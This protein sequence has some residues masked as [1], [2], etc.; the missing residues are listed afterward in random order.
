VSLP[1]FETVLLATDGSVGV[2]RAVDAAL[3]VAARFD[4]RVE[5]LYVLDAEEIDGS[6]D[7]VRDDLRNALQEVGGEAVVETRRR[8]DERG[9]AVTT[10]VREGRPADE[11]VAHAREIGAD[12]VTTGTR[13]RHGEGRLLVGSVARRVVRTCPVP[14]LTVRRLDG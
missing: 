14:V 1:A 11:I 2:E 13:G 6:P 4:A 5:A 12:V 7:A 10:A 8:A 9:V 3:D